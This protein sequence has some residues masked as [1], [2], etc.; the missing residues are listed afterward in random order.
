MNVVGVIHT[1]NAFLPLLRKGSTKKVI[2]ISSGVGDPDFTVA[3]HHSIAVPYSVS[4]AALNM[5]VAKYAAEFQEDNFVFLAIS[6][7]FVD[8]A[9][10][11]CTSH[12][13]IAK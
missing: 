12:S 11:P 13:L 5:V 4:K 3:A 8:T 2:S 6:P 9:Q 10:G 1:I 7:G